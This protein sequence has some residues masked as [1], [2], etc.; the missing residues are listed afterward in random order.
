MVQSSALPTYARDP[1]FNNLS[2]LPPGVTAYTNQTQSGQ[3]FAM[4]YPPHKKQPPG[5]FPVLFFFNLTAFSLSSGAW[6]DG[7]VNKIGPNSFG[8]QWQWIN[9]GGVVCNVQVT[10]P[11][12][13][14]GGALTGKGKGLYYLPGRADRRFEQL[15]HAQCMKDIQHAVQHVTY[16]ASRYRINPNQRVYGG[17]SAGGHLAAMLALSPNRAMSLGHGGQHNVSTVP[18]AY[19]VELVTVGS[20]ARY[21]QSS[22]VASSLFPTAAGANETVAAQLG[23][24]DATVKKFNEWRTVVSGANAQNV[25]PAILWSD[26]DPS[27]IDFHFNAN[28]WSV[29]QTTLPHDSWQNL[30]LST[31]YDDKAT[32]FMPFGN[33]PDVDTLALISNQFVNEP[34]PQKQAAQEKRSRLIQALR[35][36]PRWDHLVPQTGIWRNSLVDTVG[37]FL[38]PH[39]PG[40]GGRL[41]SASSAAGNTLFV[42]GTDAFQPIEVAPGKTVDIPGAGPLYIAA[43]DVLTPVSVYTYPRNLTA[44]SPILNETSGR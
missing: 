41:V 1:I 27:G 35:K 6:A 11:N 12:N 19:Y 10:A 24:V 40:A 31:R 42:G 5:G 28:E 30:V 23:D 29:A 16:Y 33:V 15:D 13:D 32:M 38:A 26:E 39:E 17:S 2:Y 3:R 4:Y 8:L 43:S 44:N 14:I 20:W 37:R 18:N 22:G 36:R 34:S 25:P 9:A 7:G 21:E